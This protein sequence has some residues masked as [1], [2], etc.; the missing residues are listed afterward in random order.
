MDV[1]RI[2]EEVDPDFLSDAHSR[3]GPAESG[4]SCESKNWCSMSSVQR[5]DLLLLSR[6]MVL[7]DFCSLI[8]IM[9]LVVRYK[10]EK[11]CHEEMVKMPLV[12]LKVLEVYTKSKKEYESHLKMNL[13]L[14][15]KEKCHVKPNK[16]KREGDCLYDAKTGD[17]CEERHD[18]RYGLRRDGDVRTLIMEEAHATKYSVRP[19]VNE[20]V[21]RHGVHVSSIPDKDGMYIETDG[22]SERTFRTLENMFRA[23][24]RNLVVVGILTFREAEIGESKMI[25]L[26]LEQETTKVV[27]IKERPKEAK[28]LSPW[29]GVVRFDKKGELAPRLFARL[30]EEFRFALH[31]VRSRLVSDSTMRDV[32]W[33]PIE[34]E[35]LEEPRGM[36]VRRIEEEVN[37]DFLSDAYSRTGPAD[38]CESPTS[39][40]R[41]KKKLFDEGVGTYG[42]LSRSWHT[43]GS[44]NFVVKREQA[45][46]LASGE[47]RRDD[48]WSYLGVVIARPS[49]MWERA[50]V[51]VDAWSDVRTLIMEEAHATKYSVRPGVNETVAR[52]GVHVSSIPDKDGMYIEVLERDVE[53]AEIGESKMIGLELKQETT[54]VVVI[55]ERPKKAKDLRLLFVDLPSELDHCTGELSESYTVSESIVAASLSFR[56]GSELQELCQFN[57]LSASLIISQSIKMANLSKDIQCTGSDTRPPMLDRT[58]FASWQQRIRLYCRGK[59]NGVNILKSID[60]GPFQ[61]GTFRETLTKGTEGAPHLGPERPQVYSDLSPEDKDMYN[62]DIRATNILLQ[63]LPKD[64]YSLINHYTDAKDI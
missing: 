64:I 18:S 10:A 37:L 9:E 29:K 48:G 2:E 23:C 19:G 39:R 13:E 51:V 42:Y 52:H 41:V 60:E 53:V 28:D 30:I 50:D 4:D 1:R 43:K 59:E 46:M 63:G 17:S 34:E 58:D 45:R 3:T 61:M 5:F 16:T 35:R 6:V 38:S 11:V 54:K 62:A 55:K 56:V 49:T 44:D 40:S 20:T 31:R 21:A 33:E 36:D 14:L 7:F 26:E 27:V 22:Q 8:V 12:D 25:G 57:V 15:K 24:V 32:E 47:E